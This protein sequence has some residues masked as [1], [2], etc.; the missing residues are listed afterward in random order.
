MTLIVYLWYCALLIITEGENMKMKKQR[1]IWSK[2]LFL[3]ILYSTFVSG[4]SMAEEPSLV[5]ALF[6]V[7]ISDGDSVHYFLDAEQTK[8]K[9]N[10]FMEAAENCQAEALSRLAASYNAEYNFYFS[11]QLREDGLNAFAQYLSQNKSRMDFLDSKNE[12]ALYKSVSSTCY[13]IM[14]LLLASRAS[15]NPKGS[16]KGVLE[17][18]DELL[19]E[20]PGS[21]SLLFLSRFKVRTIKMENTSVN[22]KEI[23]T[24]R[25]TNERCYRFNIDGKVSGSVNF[26]SDSRRDFEQEIYKINGEANCNINDKNVLFMKVTYYT[27]NSRKGDTE[28]DFKRRSGEIGVNSSD[29][30]FNSDIKIRYKFVTED[31]YEE[32]SVASLLNHA[33]TNLFD[34]NINITPYIGPG[35]ESFKRK[36]S[37]ENHSGYFTQ[38]GVG[39]SWTLDW[40]YKPEFF[41]KMDN[42]N[43]SS[44]TEQESKFGVKVPVSEV[45][46]VS[47]QRTKKER[48]FENTPEDNYEQ[49]ATFIVVTWKF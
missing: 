5:R 26:N 17:L 27:S 48:E 11:G 31:E 45:L 1:S 38:Y 18:R 42:K 10:F 16:S 47:V 2:P 24:N 37:S 12:T 20:Y 19:K 30:I 14:R 35:Y 4:I 49:T 3:V 23:E 8:K 21:R 13:P 43:G 46:S 39:L 9:K 28:I 25:R 40:K 29:V 32:D 41:Y 15:L 22:T 6:G 36:E 7:K 33:F 44:K 34:N